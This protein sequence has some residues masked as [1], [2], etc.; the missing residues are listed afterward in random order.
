V[1]DSDYLGDILGDLEA[2][3]WDVSRSRVKEDAVVLTGDQ[4]ADSTARL[5]ALVVDA[6][7]EVTP[8]YVKYLAKTASDRNAD[9]AFV[10]TL[11]TLTPDANS[12]AEDYGITV[13]DPEVVG[14][15]AATEATEGTAESAGSVDEL[16]GSD[17]PSTGSD[18][19]SAGS[20]EASASTDD[21]PPARND[22]PDSETPTAADEP[23]PEPTATE[24]EGASEAGRADDTETEAEPSRDAEFWTADDDEEPADDAIGAAAASSSTTVTASDEPPEAGQPPAADEPGDGHQPRATA[25]SWS[26]SPPPRDD[27][28]LLARLTSGK[29]LVVVAVALLAVGLLVTGGG[30]GILDNNGGERDPV[31]A[32]AT[33]DDSTQQF[34]NRTR[35]VGAIG[36]VHN[37]S[38]DTVK[39]TVLQPTGSGSINLS[40]ATIEWVG[41]SGA[42]VLTWAETTGST[43]FTTRAIKGDS[44]TVLDSQKDRIEVV[45]DAKAVAGR[46]DPGDKAQLQIHTQ[47]GATTNYDVNVPESLDGKIVVEL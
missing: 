12:L 44:A 47:F 35:V 11:G 37:G 10:S 32:V 21:E 1:T 43:S 31:R 41:P 16:A 20:D 28:S 36:E 8:E 46:L 7:T 30:A 45:V 3:G 13:V 27:D 42:G 17:G 14:A 6:D 34:S 23:S 15:S 18:G 22:R 25:D 5:V 24:P 4:T 9:T 38:V 40:E 19:A 26:E 29:E 2:D 33:G 39:L